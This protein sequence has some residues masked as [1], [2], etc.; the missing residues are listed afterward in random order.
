MIKR[1]LFFF[2]N[3]CLFSIST[4]SQDRNV[5]FECLSVEKG[6]SHHFTM[7][8]MQ[9]RKEFLWFGTG[10]GLNKYD[11]YRVTHYKFDPLDTT[12]L[13]KNQV[14]TLW[15]DNDKI[16]WVGTSE[17][18]CKFDPRNEKFTRIEQNAKNPFVFKYAQS[19]IEDATDNL[20][21]GGGVAEELRLTDRKTCK[22]SATN[23]AYMLVTN[24]DML[25]K[26]HYTYKNKMGTFGWA[27]LWD[28]IGSILHIMEANVLKL[29]SPI[30]GKILLIPTA[31]I[32][33]G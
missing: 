18:I 13:T 25:E 22:F 30:T 4:Y 23:Y 10:N 26:L 1:P 14:F 3:F 32:I 9:D 31:L 17:S 7:T 8:V 19:F 21:V 2:F 11:G 24:S 16:I 20:W 6:L 27:A 15:E 12:S 29:V 28:C 5:I 33:T